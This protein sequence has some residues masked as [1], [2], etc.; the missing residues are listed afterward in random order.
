MAVLLCKCSSFLI[1]LL[2]TWILNVIKNALLS[3][4][5]IKDYI[6]EELTCPELDTLDRVRI[7]LNVFFSS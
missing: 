4:P 1:S 7:S 5:Y 3:M 2:K 6:F